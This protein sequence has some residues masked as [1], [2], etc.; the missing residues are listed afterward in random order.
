MKV[1]LE[2]LKEYV[3]FDLGPRD[4]ADRLTSVGLPCEGLEEVG[5]DP[6]LELEVPSNRPDCLGVLGVAREV[7]AALGKELRVPEV[8]A[9]DGR[10]SAGSLAKLTVEDQDLCP[11]YVARVISGVKIGE[12]PEWMQRRLTA[13]GMRPLNNVVDVTNYVLFEVGQPLHA[14]DLDLLAGGAIIV[15]RARSGE[16]MELIDGSEVKLDGSELVIADEQG[17]VALAGVMGG[18]RTEVHSGTTNVLLESASFLPASIRRTSRRLGAVSESSYRFERSTDWGGVEYASRRAAALIGELAGGSVAAGSV[19]AAVPEP[20]PG[21]VTVRYWRVDKLLGRRM[22]KHAIRRILLNLGLESVYE[23]GEGITVLVPSFRPDLVRE[24]DLIEEVARH[25]GYDEIP[26]H[27]RLSVRLPRVG[28]GD[29]ACRLLRE[30]MVALGF[31]ETVTISVLARK[32]GQAI[33]PWRSARPVLI[34]NPPRAGQDLLR[35]SLLPSL[36]EVRRANQSAGCPELS[37]FDLGR[38][39][40]ARPDGSV[41]ERRLF[42][43]LDDRDGGAEESFGRLRAVLEVTCSLFRGTENLRVVP[44]ELPYMGAGESARIFL[45]EEFLG[46][47]GRLNPDL[48]RLFDLRGCPALLEVDLETL[49][50][51]GLSRGT[52]RALPRFP[53]IRRDVALILDE[54]VNWAEVSALVEEVPC[55]L[56]QSVEFLNVYRGKQAGPGRKSLAFSVTYRSAERTLT[57]AEVNDLHSALVEHLTGKLG[58]S[59]RS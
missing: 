16:S 13:V 29:Q 19:E 52:Y 56:R 42:A 58:A 11:R 4:L 31:S 51:R 26:A 20:K 24:I 38:A 48:R 43:A 9:P 55:E 25:F 35:Q 34:T 30:R 3:D 6:V 39:Y 21:Q 28:P 17:P 46:V 40:L 50:S 59:L 15:R 45:G 12:S 2:W 22:E 27:T 54:K 8:P 1:S 41:N 47:M 44:S 57:D 53:G 33:G 14:F 49:I 5:G 37:V 18:S 32:Q 23:S 36:L 7:A 10:A